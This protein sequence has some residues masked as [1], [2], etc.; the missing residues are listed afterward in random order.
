LDDFVWI[1]QLEF[2]A[3]GLGFPVPLILKM[4]VLKM[5]KSFRRIKCLFL[6]VVFYYW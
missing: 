6:A 1:G 5:R 3:I 4:R 2:L